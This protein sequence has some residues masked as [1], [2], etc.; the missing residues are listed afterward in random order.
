M[1]SDTIPPPPSSGC[2]NCGATLAFQ[3]APRFCNQC[4]QRVQPPAPRVLVHETLA[5]YGRSLVALVAH[6]GR[7]TQAYVAG[8]REHYVPP[9]RLYLAASFLFFFVVKVL[10]AGGGSHLVVAPALDRSGK[11]ITEASNPAAYRA[12]MAEMQSCVDHPGSCSW[13]RTLGARISLK[14]AAQAGRPD[15]VAQQMIGLAPNAV[16][17][18]LPV[19]A[20]LL[21]LAYR[22]RSLRY[23]THFVF[24]LHMHA[25]GFLALLLLWKL[26]TAAALIGALTLPPYGL[27]ALHRVYGGRWWTTLARAAAL[28]VAY[29]PA[30]FATMVGLS[31]ASLFLA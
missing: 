5:R 7:L 10:S 15:A 28:V 31:I 23:G 4:G 8:R 2:A 9:L 14:G 24:S 12:V 21:M 20:A 22:S 3:P 27:W 13:G 26:P 18:L 30:L 17:V 29:L 16:F 19:F 6:P 25:F 1:S 11:P